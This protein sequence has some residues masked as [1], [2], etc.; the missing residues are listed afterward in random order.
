MDAQLRDLDGMVADV[1]V[2]GGGLA[3]LA[4]AA[5][6]AK[7]DATR[8]VVLLDV[9][10]GGGHAATDEVG[11][12]RFN[13]GAHALYRGGPAHA[14]LRDLGV[15]VSGANPP[16][17]GARARLGDRTG[18]L[19][20]GALTLARTDLL[21]GGDKVRLG[22]LLAGFSRLRAERLSG[23]TI[24]DWLD[25]RG[26]DG[27]ARGFAELLVRL[28][29]YNADHDVISADV[30]IGQIQA[31]LGKGVEYLHS[32]WG[33]MVDGLQAAA[34][35]NGAR[36]VTGARVTAVVPEGRSVRIELGD[37]AL[38]ARRVVLAAGTPEATAGLLPD[39]GAMPAAWQRLGPP[40]M[41]S[42]LDLGLRVTPEVQFLLGIDHPIYM[43]CH[44]PAAAGLAPRGGA[45]VQLL[46]YLAA[47]D[48]PSPA[49]GRAGFAEHAALAGIDV[50]RAEE[51]RYLHRM[52]AVSAQPT[53]ASGGLRGRPAADS[54]GLDNVLVAGDWVGPEG[55]LAD[56]S[57][58]SG[59]AAGRAAIA[60]L[61]SAATVHA[62]GGTAA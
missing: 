21:G 39:A 52:A 4:A 62:V 50:G 19:P 2:V 55:Y 47:G 58:A 45:T 14:V 27:T 42:C 11:R 8:S 34:R 30:V 25:D 61:A 33:T 29:T 44:A 13:R 56:A 31:A 23:V 20:L 49:E 40:A 3:G 38:H 32:G 10:G 59:A 22:K 17:K 57:L 53:P 1:V 16:L 37:D 48:D 12:Y 28:T 26:L 24:A 43:I 54:A 6:A 35:D 60:D 18:L 5:T 9:Q 41:T 7:A 46:R 15:R 51:S 36:L